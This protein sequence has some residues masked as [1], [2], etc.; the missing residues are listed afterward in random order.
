MIR[1]TTIATAIASMS[2]MAATGI[3]PAAAHTHSRCF[4]SSADVPH[5]ARIAPVH[6]PL[7]ASCVAHS[8]PKAKAPSAGKAAAT[9]RQ[10]LRPN[11]FHH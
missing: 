5:A 1:K 10:A 9:V 4:A 11:P 7:R 8:L 6:S 2:L 3:A